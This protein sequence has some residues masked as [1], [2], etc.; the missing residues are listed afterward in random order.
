ML[1]TSQMS[2]LSFFIYVIAQFLGCFIGSSIV[3]VTY[4]DGLKNYQNY[5]Y[6]LDTAAA[7][8]N[9]AYFLNLMALFLICS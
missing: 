4:L 2:L 7:G 1:I 9:Y 6:S 3:Y 8:I 5:T